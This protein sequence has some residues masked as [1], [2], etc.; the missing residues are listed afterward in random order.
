MRSGQ[1]WGRAAGFGG[2]GGGHHVI[3][4]ANKIMASFAV[5][6]QLTFAWFCACCG[7]GGCSE[8]PMGNSKRGLVVER[9]V[10]DQNLKMHTLL[11][12]LYSV[13]ILH[14]SSLSLNY[15]EMTTF[16]TLLAPLSDLCNS[17]R[18]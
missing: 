5:L 15:P 12:L 17:E 4:H 1:W 11:T 9:K 10:G 7:S 18:H 13:I 6:R 8:V 16:N 3:S 14:V 2:L